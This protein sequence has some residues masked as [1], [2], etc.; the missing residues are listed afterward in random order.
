MITK[1]DDYAQTT[2]RYK[3]QRSLHLVLATCLE[4]LRNL[5]IDAEIVGGV[6]EC[7]HAGLSVVRVAGDSSYL[8]HSKLATTSAIAEVWY[9]SDGGVRMSRGTAQ[10]R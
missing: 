3:L 7:S 2:C 4:G 9:A 10:R 6:P 8:S 1:R 5:N